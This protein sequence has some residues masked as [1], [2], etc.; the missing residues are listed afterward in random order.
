M[1]HLIEKQLWDYIDDELNPS[2]RERIELLLKNDPIYQET[3]A[4]I[5]KLNSLMLSTDIEEPS[6]GFTRNVL[7]KIALEPTPGSIKSIIDKRVINA[8]AGFFILTILWLLI[9]VFTKVEWSNSLVSMP[10]VKLQIP[11]INIPNQVNHVLIYGF[12]F[13][14]MIVGLYLLDGFLRKKI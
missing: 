7:D 12:V 1:N 14:D 4:N 3:Y 6:T 8:I 11:R 2:E 9:Y 5:L 13:L 10:S